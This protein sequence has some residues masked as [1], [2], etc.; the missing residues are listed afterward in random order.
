MKGTGAN[1]AGILISVPENVALGSHHRL[2]RRGCARLEIGEGDVCVC[3]GGGG[4]GG[5]GY[6]FFF[7][8]LNRG[9]TADISGETNVKA[10]LL[11]RRHGCAPAQRRRTRR[12]IDSHFVLCVCDGAEWKSNPRD[13][14]VSALF[15][16][17][18][19]P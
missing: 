6:F 8:L 9:K 1:R 3:G 2:K 7:N 15:F 12:I 17:V 19:S 10:R 16:S 14:S 11:F 5:T 18:I 13:P 4:G